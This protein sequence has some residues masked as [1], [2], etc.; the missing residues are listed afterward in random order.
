MSARKVVAHWRHFLL[1]ALVAGLLLRGHAEATALVAALAAVTLAWA[2]SRPS[3]AALAALLV[4]GGSLLAAERLRSIDHSELSG[5]FG[6]WVTA[7]GHV[8]KRERASHGTSRVRLRLESLRMPGSRARGRGELIQL[9]APAALRVGRLSIG[10]EL[11]ATGGLS[12]LPPSAPG[13]DFDYGAYL[14]RNGVHAVLRAESV[15]STGRSRGGPAGFVDAVRRRA[16]RGVEAGLPPSLAQLAR[17]MVLG[18]DEQ[19][20]KAMSEDFKRSGLAHLLA[21]SGQ[22]VTLLAL[23][24]FPVLG[25]LGL[26][27]RTRLL[28]VLALIA[29]YVPLT[30]A[31][32]SIVRAG[33][34]GA[35]A[36]VA[37][38]SGRPASRWYALLG[39]AAVSLIL[40]PRAWQD[41]GWQ[42]SFAAVAGIF[43]LMRPIAGR[44]R[45]LPSALADGLA[46]TAAA[47]VATAPLMAFQ[48]GQ[49]SIVS[50]PANMLALPA[51]AP[52]M[53][54]G[55]LAGTVAQL[56]VAPAAAINSI[57]SLCLAFIAFIAH[58]SASPPAAVAA[59]RIGSVTALAAVYCCLAATAWA[60]VAGPSRIVRRA[61]PLVAIVAVTAVAAIVG[62]ALHARPV[63]VSDHFSATF[64]DVGQGDAI[65]MRTPRGGAV[66]VDCGPP[67]ASVTAKLRSRGVA[68]LDLVVLTHPQRDHVG[69]CADVLESI[70]AAKLVG[71][72]AAHAAPAHAG[73]TFVIDGLRLRVLSP[74]RDYDPRAGEPNDQAVVLLASYAGFDMLLPADAE[75]DV[76]GALDLPALDLI[77]VAHHG[78]ADEGLSALLERT[79]PRIAVIEVGASNPYGHPAASTIS[80]LATVPKVYRTDRDGDVTIT[81]TSDGPRFSTSR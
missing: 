40:D 54:A 79:R 45:R 55:M 80:E 12:D 14:R 75:S 27:R 25:L 56:W 81:L 78:S 52:V 74:A 50:L 22:N 24:A 66:L 48:F 38:L 61:A 3:V 20:P 9:R 26:A 73:Q 18:E 69:G 16:E 47:T 49:V 10:S 63:V 33:A 36:T 64:I 44:L 60:I 7:R 2:T 41:A 62:V 31:G 57:A 6:S 77:K 76:T 72:G 59:V 46:I 32:P 42:L 71:V 11:I 70:P 8:V 13:D 28:V 30:G 58:W 1:A 17:G 21:V 37:A 15:R 19:I 67:E 5:S 43:V 53:W 29:L 35:A 65:L 23:L 68:R 51:V 4:I 34:M 39:A